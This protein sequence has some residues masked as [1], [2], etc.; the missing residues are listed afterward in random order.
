MGN[1]ADIG[2]FL[3]ETFA[4]ARDNLAAI[5]IFV[6]V[7]SA[8]GVASDWLTLN[9]D[10]LF[11]LSA[12]A[13]VAGGFVIGIVAMIIT[14]AAQ[15][16]LTAAMLNSRNELRDNRLRLL[17]YVGL[18]I[19]FMIAMIF[20]FILLV[21]PALIMIT[22]WSIAP[23]FLIAGE[24]GVIESFGASWE[25][26]SGLSWHIFGGILVLAIVGGSLIFVITG[27][28]VAVSEFSIGTSILANLVS[29]TFTA[30]FMAFAV[31]VY[32]LLADN[33]EATSEVFA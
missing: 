9:P 17:P 26:T 6:V 21:V 16:F 10:A 25:A 14:F 24:K 31:A 5:A 22:R 27:A 23:C 3:S 32:H 29:N 1:D 12:E 28:A 33:T 11:G 8:F 2:G 19:L 30:I 18:Y 15:Y 13:L 7:I 20:G 4:I